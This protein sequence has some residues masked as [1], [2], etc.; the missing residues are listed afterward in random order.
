MTEELGRILLLC[1]LCHSW[2]SVDRQD[3]SLPAFTDFLKCS[4]ETGI[5]YYKSFFFPKT[6]PPLKIHFYPFICLQYILFLKDPIVI[7]QEEYLCYF[8]RLISSSFLMFQIWSTEPY[9]CGVVLSSKCYLSVIVW[10]LMWIALIFLSVFCFSSGH[11]F[12]HIV[13]TLKIWFFSIRELNIWCYCWT[14][15]N[16][17]F[18]HLLK[19]LPCHYSFFLTFMILLTTAA[20]TWFGKGGT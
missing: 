16:R 11:S 9:F 4:E 1:G 12:L 14:L 15:N 2:W 19:C 6:N 13:T 5:K 8:I 3:L 17:H 18:C 20:F 7:W 10:L